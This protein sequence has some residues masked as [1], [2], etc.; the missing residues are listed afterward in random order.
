MIQGLDMEKQESWRCLHEVRPGSKL[1]RSLFNSQ[2]HCLSALLLCVGYL[3]S[4]GLAFLLGTTTGSSYGTPGWIKQD[5]T[6]PDIDLK[7]IFTPK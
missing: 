3:I 7:V 5:N 1:Y 2:S 4:L 6:M